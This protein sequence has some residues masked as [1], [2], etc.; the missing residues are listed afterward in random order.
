MAS[1]KSVALLGLSLL[2]QASAVKLLALNF[3]GQ[4][5]SLNLAFQSST[6]ASLKVVQNITACGVTPTWLHL[7]EE[8]RTVYCIDESWLNEGLGSGNLSQWSAG[9]DFN[10]KDALT[11]TGSTDTEGNSVHGFTYG[12]PDGRSFI[13]TSEYSPS[14][15]TT[16]R[17]PITS[18]TKALQKLEFTMAAPGPRPD[19]QDKPHPHAAFTD[20]TG[21]FLIV[22]D[23]GADLTRIFKIDGKTGELTA[24]PAIAS[25]P[26]DGPRHGLFRKT[27]RAL[28][29]YSLNEVSSSVGVY[30]VTYPDHS[31]GSKESCLSL[32]LVQT[33]S[34]YGP[35]VPLG[36]VTVKSAEIRT[37]GNFLY[38]SNRNDTTFGFEQDSIAIFK[39][40]NDGKLQFQELTNA[41]GYYPRSFSF[42]E[43]GTYAAIAGQTTANIAIV[44]RDTKTGKL[45]PLVTNLILPPR[46]TYGGEDGVSNVIWVE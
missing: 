1:V 27:G 44:K 28:K 10:K 5:Y 12:G 21:D 23:L 43:A 38:A 7:D 33:L 13:I 15:I 3:A 20:P 34:N 14:T 42:N 45:G 30:D 37:V 6:K 4:F 11:L 31:H 35:N 9:P 41:H 19:R 22:P 8:T 40:G 26:G 24:C 46:G 2:S 18:S 39:I 16:Y 25:L 17:L 29:Y 32:K 36:N